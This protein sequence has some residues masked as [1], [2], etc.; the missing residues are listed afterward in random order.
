MSPIIITEPYYRQLVRTIRV[1]E[2]L[3]SAW[4]L[5]A[6]GLLL[7]LVPG[8]S[9]GGLIGGGLIAETSTLHSGPWPER[10]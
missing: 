3:R 5:S 9:I 1:Y 4:L 8:F 7:L 6:S 2:P 10:W